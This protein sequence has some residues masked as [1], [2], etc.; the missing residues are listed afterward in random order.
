MSARRRPPSVRSVFLYLLAFVLIATG[1]LAAI[2]SPQDRLLARWEKFD[3]AA[4]VPV[5]C[6]QF[7]DPAVRNDMLSLA[8]EFVRYSAI[9][10]LSVLSRRLDQCGPLPP[11]EAEEFLND[12]FYDLRNWNTEIPSWKMEI[13]NHYRSRLPVL[14]EIGADLAQVFKKV[15][16]TFTFKPRGHYEKLWLKG[17]WNADGRL[18][19]LGGWADLPLR[20]AGSGAWTRHDDLG[21][22]RANDLYHAVVRT[23]KWP[24]G[25]SI[26]YA[27]FRADG[28]ARVEIQPLARPAAEASAQS[29]SSTPTAR[30]GVVLVDGATWQ[31]I[32]PLVYMGKLPH[33]RRLL[34][35]G[36]VADL[37]STGKYETPFNAFTAYTGKLQFRHGVSAA[38]EHLQPSTGRKA[39][40]LWKM[41]SDSGK[42]SLTVGLLDSFPPDAVIGKVVTDAFFALVA[43]R[44]KG[45]QELAM[46]PEAR[47]FAQRF[48][49]SAEG[50]RGF[51]ELLG[52]IDG[53]AATTYPPDL[54]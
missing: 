34:E 14:G 51:L 23:A 30:V 2:P 50:I 16:V 1:I 38:E 53:T 3:K 48:G 52:W 12:V 37:V 22:T 7:K 6:R 36:A 27:N 35:E 45:V 18:D 10:R 46:S 32:L 5:D 42:S 19:H 9:R 11:A 15:P 8:G 25:E 39:S 43:R 17:S 29:A 44:Q 40:P 31:V 4:A 41:A 21:A 20:E 54:E 24:A 33:F 26:G 28:A 47:L 13:L 49:V